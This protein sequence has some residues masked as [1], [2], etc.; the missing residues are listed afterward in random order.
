MIIE[1]HKTNTHT[2]FSDAPIS[3]GVLWGKEKKKGKEA[4]FPQWD[5]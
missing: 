2:I 3:I 5:I 1:T 4:V